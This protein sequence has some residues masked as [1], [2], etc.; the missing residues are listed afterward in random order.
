MPYS[1]LQIAPGIIHTLGSSS[2]AHGVN[3][4]LFSSNAEKV[5]LCLFS[6]D[7]SRQLQRLALPDCT[8]ARWPTPLKVPRCAGASAGCCMV[9]PRTWAS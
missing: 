2:D 3:F 6:D 9:K 4:A 1:K 8:S 7:G 5:E